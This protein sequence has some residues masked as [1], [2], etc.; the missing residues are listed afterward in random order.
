LFISTG[1]KPIHIK[2][3]ETAELYNIGR[4]NSYKKLQID[5]DKPPTNGSTQQTGQ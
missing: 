2:I 5:R 4:R 3:K 1:L